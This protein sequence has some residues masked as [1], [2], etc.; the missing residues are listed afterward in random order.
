MIHY[1]YVTGRRSAFF[2]LLLASSNRRRRLDLFFFFR[3][4]DALYSNLH[5]PATHNAAPC[6]SGPHTYPTSAQTH[7][8]TSFSD[9]PSRDRSVL[10]TTRGHCGLVLSWR[11]PFHFEHVR[12]DYKVSERAEGAQR[13]SLRLAICP[14]LI[15]DLSSPPPRTPRHQKKM[16]SSLTCSVGPVQRQGG[17][18]E[19][20]GESPSDRTKVRIRVLGPSS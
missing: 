5:V 15:L 3:D 2:S 9:R 12:R 4:L 16:V 1:V 20:G 19:R 7:S 14:H 18:V 17:G 11:V 13:D 8:H 10:M 6:S